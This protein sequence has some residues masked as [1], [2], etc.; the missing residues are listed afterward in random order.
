MVL[1]V[2]MVLAIRKEKG[3]GVLFVYAHL[4]WGG[5]VS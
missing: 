3:R 1:K 4:T 5:G 2:R